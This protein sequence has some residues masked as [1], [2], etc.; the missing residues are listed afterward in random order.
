MTAKINRPL[1]TAE[2]DLLLVL[3]VLTVATQS[4]AD[5]ATVAEALDQLAAEGRSILR[6]DDQDAFV[7]VADHVIVH[8]DR[9]WLAVNQHR[10]GW[11]AN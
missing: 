2:K 4:G 10:A 11:A 6:V 5:A 9:T 1:T 8:A 3:A 7:V